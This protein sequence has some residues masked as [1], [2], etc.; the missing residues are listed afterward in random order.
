LRSFANKRSG[1]IE[2]VLKISNEYANIAESSLNMFR[3][4]M[5][6]L[7]KDIDE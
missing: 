5:A 4:S 7:K 2:L 6:L 3:M 1:E